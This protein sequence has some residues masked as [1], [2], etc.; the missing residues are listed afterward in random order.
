MPLTREMISALPHET[1]VYIY[2][3]AEGR[4]LYVG[5]AV[6][7][8]K[9]VASYLSAARRDLRM[10]RLV[11][12]VEEVRWIGASDEVEALIMEARLIRE[13][14]PPFNLALKNT[15]FYPYLEITLGEDFPRVRITRTP[16]DRK[17]RYI[18]PFTDV[19]A[20]RLALR[21][22]QPVFRFRTCNR[23]IEAGARRRRVRPCFNYHLRLCDAP[24]AG[25]VGREEYRRKVKAFI[26]FFSGKKDNLIRELE[27][28]MERA[29]AELRFEEA[30][31]LRDRIRALRKLSSP[32]P[33]QRKAVTFVD[34]E[35]EKALAELKEALGLDEAPEWIEGYDISNLGGESAVGSRVVFAGGLPFKGG[36]RRY[37]IKTVEGSNDY[38]MLAEV[39][40]RRLARIESG[41]EAPPSLVL[42]DGGKGQ[43]SAVRAVMEEVGR[44]LPLVGLAKKEE[45]VHFPDGRPPLKLPRNSAALRLLQQVRDEAHRFAQDYHHLLRAKR[46]FG[47]KYRG[48]RRRGKREEE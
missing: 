17:S 48:K 16:S 13:L 18:G 9:R 35:P 10:R 29:A 33:Y 23:S 44:A 31:E 14:K 26:L 38:A 36:Y 27:R 40:R 6:D 41:E 24:C 30:A 28:Q 25:F 11:S 3:D 5:K 42:V 22:A 43:V 39:L 45:V 37:R 46:I 20:L 2:L 34:M 1:G 7:L 47:R 4:E 15:D 21:A 8:R 12:Q 19:G 32:G